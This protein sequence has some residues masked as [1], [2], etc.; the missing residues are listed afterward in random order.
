MIDR[1]KICKKWVLMMVKK[2]TRDSTL[3]IRQN[4]FRNLD[5][6]SRSRKTVNQAQK[7]SPSLTAPDMKSK[8][9]QCSTLCAE[10]SAHNAIVPVN[11]ITSV[12]KEYMI[13]CVWMTPFR[14]TLIEN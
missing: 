14:L 1:F 8:R 4:K 11:I 13:T 7:K 3:G 5:L 6:D 9:M 2:F 10:A 12:K